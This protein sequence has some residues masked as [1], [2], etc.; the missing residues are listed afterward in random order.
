M[1]VNEIKITR[2]LATL[3]LGLAQKSP[4]QEICGLIGAIDEKPQTV[5][6]VTNA[7]SDPSREFAMDSRAQIDAFKAMRAKG[8]TLFGIYH[9][10]PQSPPVPSSKDLEDLGYPEALQLIISLDT[11]GVLEMRAYRKHGK[12]ALEEVHLSV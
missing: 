1:P 11:K 12:D 9:S 2:P 5:Y 7:A 6:P 3:L 4:Q 8:E 10:H